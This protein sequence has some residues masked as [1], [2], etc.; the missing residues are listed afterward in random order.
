MDFIFLSA[1][2]GTVLTMI[3]AIY[4]IACQWK[5][6]LATRMKNLPSTL[7]LRPTVHLDFAIPKCHCPA[8]KLACQTPHSLNLKPGSGRTDGEGIERDW[9]MFN[10]AANSTKEMGMG[11]RHDT[12]DDLFGYHNWQKT[13]G[14]GLSLKRKYLIA[15]VESKRHAELH[16]EFCDSVPSSTQV[17]WT[18]MIVEWERDNKKRNPYV[19]NVKRT[20]TLIPH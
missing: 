5:V 7:Q 15:A 6:N 12:L 18:R 19:A 16:Q 9:S 13:A 3:M 14:L 11:S 20:Y 17:E 1:I 8:H 4:D 10:P 2:S